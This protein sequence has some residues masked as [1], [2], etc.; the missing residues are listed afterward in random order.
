MKMAVRRMQDLP[1]SMKIEEQRLVCKINDCQNPFFLWHGLERTLKFQ[2]LQNYEKRSKNHSL[3]CFR[4]FGK[5]MVIS[6]QDD[7]KEEPCLF[8]FREMLFVG[9]N[10]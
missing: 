10:I 2:S 3:R 4:N 9:K 5:S 1:T 6:H 8:F 7:H